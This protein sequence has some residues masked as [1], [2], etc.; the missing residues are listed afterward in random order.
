MEVNYLD[1]KRNSRQEFRIAVELKQKLKE[2]ADINH[3]TVG[4]YITNLI[5]K[6]IEEV[7]IIKVAPAER[8][9]ENP[10]K[11]L[12][13]KKKNGINAVE[14]YS[15]L[16]DSLQIDFSAERK[17]G[18]GLEL[19]DLKSY[20]H[21]DLCLFGWEIIELKEKEDKAYQFYLKNPNS[22]FHF[23][24]KYEK[25]VKD[26]KDYIEELKNRNMEDLY[27]CRGGKE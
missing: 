4:D 9:E 14:R 24:K 6:D 26:T 3:K 7:K 19:Q 16:M 17:L 21:N 23:K 20:I 15:D 25:A 11:E 8:K 10:F 12:E 22:K 1:F 13:E 2:I 5:L 18:I 27:F